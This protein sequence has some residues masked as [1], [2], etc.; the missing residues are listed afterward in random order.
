MVSDRRRQI[1]CRSLLGDTRSRERPPAGG[2]MVPQICRERPES[3]LSCYAKP[4]D[5]ADSRQGRSRRPSTRIVLARTGHGRGERPSGSRI[6]TLP[7]IW[8]RCCRGCTAWRGHDRQAGYTT[9]KI[10]PR[11]YF[12]D[13]GEE[14]ALLTVVTIRYWEDLKTTEVA[15]GK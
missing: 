8:K 1:Q 2:R 9:S 12:F 14:V 5:Y 3:P 13:K 11:I 10:G 4:W 7:Y 15:F 6:G